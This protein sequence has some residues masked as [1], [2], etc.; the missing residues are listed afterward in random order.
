[1][2]GRKELLNILRHVWSHIIM[3]AY[4]S[5]Q[6]LNV[7]KDHG[8]QRLRDVML[9]VQCKGNAYRY[10]GATVKSNTTP[11]YDTGYKTSLAMHNATVQQ[12]LTTV[13]SNLTLAIVILHAQA[14][15]ASKRNAVQFR[16]P[17][18]PFIASLAA[19][20]FVVSSQG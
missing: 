20:S 11:C 4:G 18:P 1:M 10:R 13:S 9:A 12:P 16:C 2:I 14:G 6:V 3:L 15:F 17:C 5:W 19:Q 8:F 7:W